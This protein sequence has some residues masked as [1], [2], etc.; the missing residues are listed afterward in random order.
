MGNSQN[1]DYFIWLWAFWR[2][3][4]RRDCLLASSDVLHQVLVRSTVCDFGRANPLHWR[5]R[6]SEARLRGVRD[7]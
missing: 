3:Y 2:R 1:R 4:Q 7:G 5:A 6:S